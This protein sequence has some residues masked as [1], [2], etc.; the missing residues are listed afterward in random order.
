[1]GI[2][3]CDVFVNPCLYSIIVP[4]APLHGRS[5]CPMR[6]AQGFT[7]RLPLRKVQRDGP[8]ADLLAR[9]GPTQG[10]V[11]NKQPIPHRKPSAERDRAGTRANIGFDVT[12][13]LAD[14]R[15]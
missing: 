13:S 9:S 8:R 5:S 4:L 3:T 1:M 11:R 14:L 6:S 12:V 10:R 15:R 7:V 2:K